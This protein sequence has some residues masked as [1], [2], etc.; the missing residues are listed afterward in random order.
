[1]GY[2]FDRVIASLGRRWAEDAMLWI[3][4]AYPLGRGPHIAFRLLRREHVPWA[5][6]TLARP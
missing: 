2:D 6:G 4:L 5:S 3:G 1:M